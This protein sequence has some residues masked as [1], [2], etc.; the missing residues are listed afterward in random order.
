MRNKN[1]KAP[2]SPCKFFRGCATIFVEKA[3]NSSVDEELFTH[4]S[5]PVKCLFKNKSGCLASP[6]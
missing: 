1:E 6:E 3:L 2:K 5:S 4:S